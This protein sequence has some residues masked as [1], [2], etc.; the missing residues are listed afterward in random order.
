MCNALSVDNGKEEEQENNKNTAKDCNSKQQKHYGPKDK[1]CNVN[2]ISV[3]KLEA[4]ML[5]HKSKGIEERKN[6]NNRNK[7]ICYLEVSQPKECKKYQ[8]MKIKRIILR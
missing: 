1:A 8:N 2:G 4:E 7:H 5:K 6:I 3:A